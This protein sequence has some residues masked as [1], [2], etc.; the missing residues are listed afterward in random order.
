MSPLFAAAFPAWPSPSVVSD[1]LPWPASLAMAGSRLVRVFSGDWP[2]LCALEV[3]VSSPL[4]LALTAPSATKSGVEHVG[5]RKLRK[6]TELLREV[7]N[8]FLQ[9]DR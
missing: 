6:L 3:S 1:V 7:K 5:R 8:L 2:K 9:I 4:S